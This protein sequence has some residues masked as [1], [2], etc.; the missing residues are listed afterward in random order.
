FGFQTPVFGVGLPFGPSWTVGKRWDTEFR[1]HACL[2]GGYVA[3]PELGDESSFKNQDEVFG[4]ELKPF[5]KFPIWQRALV[6]F[7]GPGFNIIFAYLI[8]LF[9]L[10]CQG[11]PT[12]QTVVHSLIESNPIALKA[13]VKA[14]DR[15]V[16]IDDK[17]I[18]TP[19]EAVNYLSSKKGEE[20]TLHIEREKQPSDIKL[21]TSP[22]GKV[23]MVLIVKGPVSYEKVNENIIGVFGL[24]AQRLYEL[25]AS[26]M[27]A[28]KLIV[29]GIW[30]N[31]VTFGQPKQAAPSVG[32]QDVHGIL[33]VLKIGAEIARQ[34]WNQLFMFTILISMD[35]AII[36]LVPFPPLDGYHLASQS[37]EAVRGR[38]MS[39][40]VQGEIIKFGWVTIFILFAV[41]M[42]NDVTALFTGK[43][44]LKKA[45]EKENKRID[46]KVKEVTKGQTAPAPATTPAQEETKPTDSAADKVDS[47][48]AKDEP[49]E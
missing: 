23:G 24:A 14:E 36:N 11:I 3:I 22:D 33:A 6:A 25:T 16:S 31:I 15:I 42:V 29:K 17:K 34:D 7:A 45:E 44:D 48:Q 10:F 41:I 27:E 49:T 39:E 38:P 19:D 40:R 12:Y 47:P 13:G 5:K 43:L 32:I 1:L 46:A 2:L 9:M 18:S 37:I 28:L 35:L 20:V 26:M 30:T 4:V 21:T 8:M